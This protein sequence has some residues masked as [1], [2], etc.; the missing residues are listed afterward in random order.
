MND[1]VFCKIVAGEIPSNKVYEDDHV[2]AFKDLH[3]VAP[4]HVLIVPKAHFDD[5]HA[6]ASSEAG[7]EAMDHIMCALPAIVEAV[8]LKDSGFRLINNCGEA[9]G[10][11][12]MHVHIHLVGGV[13]LGPR[14]L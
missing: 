3:P 11:T 1:C 8:G 14:I 7:R 12:V 5:I 2:V 4:V 13:E 9:A 10:Q 6:M